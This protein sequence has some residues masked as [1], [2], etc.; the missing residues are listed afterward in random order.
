M[1]AFNVAALCFG[2]VFGAASQ[3]QI[4]FYIRAREFRLYV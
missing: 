3:V 4:W 1:K 2:L